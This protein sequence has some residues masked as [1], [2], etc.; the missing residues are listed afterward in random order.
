M[1]TPC[2]HRLGAG[3]P[4][5]WT[6][7]LIEQ[8]GIQCKVRIVILKLAYPCFILLIL[9]SLYLDKFLRCQLHS[10]SVYLLIYL[11]I[12]HKHNIKIRV[13][14]KVSSVEYFCRGWFAVFSGIP[15]RCLDT[16]GA[17][18]TCSAH[19]DLSYIHRFTQVGPHYNM[20]E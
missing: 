2:P 6:T 16:D 17:V 10:W 3:L 1:G 11:F 4:K 14:L 12:L 15:S 18:L 20:S 19:T 13:C 7:A 9:S 8:K 5:M